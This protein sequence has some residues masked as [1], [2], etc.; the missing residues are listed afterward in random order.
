MDDETVEDDEGATEPT[1]HVDPAR[2]YKGSSLLMIAYMACMLTKCDRANMKLL[3]ALVQFSNSETASAAKDALDGRSIP[4]DYTNPLLHV[5][6]SAIDASGQVNHGQSA[7]SILL[8]Y[9][10]VVGHNGEV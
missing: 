8:N 10:L 4:R 5:A 2:D 1:R 3:N 7:V 6:P 9:S